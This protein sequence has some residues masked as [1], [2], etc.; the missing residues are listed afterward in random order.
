MN[1]FRE[2]AQN[3]YWTYALV[4]SKPVAASLSRFGV[5][6]SE[7]LKALMEG[8]ISSTARKRTFLSGVASACARAH[9][10]S[11]QM[12]VILMMHKSRLIW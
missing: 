2:G 8:R 9:D 6:A 10:S 7:K 5:F 4:N 11:A 12:T 3:E 1:E